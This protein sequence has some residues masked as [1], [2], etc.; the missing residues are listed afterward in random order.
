MKLVISLV[1][2]LAAGSTACTSSDAGGPLT[3]DTAPLAGTAYGQP[4]TFVAGTQDAGFS[5]FYSVAW[6]CSQF[7]EPGGGAPT[8]LTTLPTAPGEYDLGLSEGKST[9]TFVQP[10]STNS[11]AVQGKIR[12][13]SVTAT[14]I[15]GGVVA[16][17]DGD[18]YVSGTFSLAVCPP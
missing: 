2:A 8:L 5:S 6:D 10:P 18:N 14:A 17:I 16:R 15:T 7:G 9:I 1:A 11:I 4:W 3:I 12:I 13:D